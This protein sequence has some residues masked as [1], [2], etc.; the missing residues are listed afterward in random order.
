MSLSP[1][2]E[3][4]ADATETM[5][6]CSSVIL[7]FGVSL[8]DDDDPCNR[9]GASAAVKDEVKFCP[10][11]GAIIPIP[12]KFAIPLKIEIIYLCTN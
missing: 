1:R 10:P 4:E 5:W 6:S 9:V 7:I 3:S 12:N 8:V 11:P 2:D